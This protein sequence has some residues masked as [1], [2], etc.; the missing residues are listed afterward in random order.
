MY[1]CVISL[2]PKFWMAVCIFQ[3]LNLIPEGTLADKKIKTPQCCPE[4][5]VS[6]ISQ[7]NPHIYCI[8]S[9]DEVFGCVCV[10]CCVGFSRIILCC[11]P[12]PDLSFLCAG[13]LAIGSRADESWSLGWSFWQ[14]IVCWDHLTCQFS[15][16]QWTSVATVNKVNITY[17]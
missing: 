12:L 13:V 6:L 5:S 8:L 9:T 7:L 11:F 4:E 3:K 14:W 17:G 2:T 16:E 10:D 1:V 15:S